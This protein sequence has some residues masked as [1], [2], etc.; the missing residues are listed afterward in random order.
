MFS[1]Y[2]R[3]LYIIYRSIYAYF[4]YIFTSLFDYGNPSISD[5][6]FNEPVYNVSA[7]FLFKEQFPQVYIP[8]LQEVYW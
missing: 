5:L 8:F 2:F 4:Q 7:R 1:I 3:P 6:S